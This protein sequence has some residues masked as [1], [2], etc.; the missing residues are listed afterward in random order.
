MNKMLIPY[1]IIIMILRLHFMFLISFISI[2]IHEYIHYFIAK[3]YG[4]KGY[5]IEISPLGCSLKL[6]EIEEASIKEDL[7][8]S[9]LPPIING[10]FFL[11][12][13]FGYKVLNFAI[14]FQIYRVNMAIFLIN[15]I[16]AFPLD[17]GRALR[18]IIYLKKSYKTSVKITCLISIIIGIL[19]IFLYIFLLIY[20]INNISIL[21]IGIFMIISSII[22]RRRLVY[23]IM[24]DVVKKIWRFSEKRYVENYTISIY[25][26]SSLIEGAKL[27]DKK[28]YGIFYILD[29]EMIIMGIITESELFNALKDKGN[30]TFMELLNEEKL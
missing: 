21:I 22:E 26:K 27:I 6:K 15:I 9:L 29:E 24:A 14:F 4:Y 17:G 8:I 7:I 12:F 23:L 25:Y 10:I 2:A 5:N 28:K 1:I 30:I 20:R 13:F 18:D 16:P 11:I 3:K 19:F